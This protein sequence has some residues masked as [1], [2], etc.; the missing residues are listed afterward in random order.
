MT[1]PSEPLFLARQSYRR[2]RLAD[3][4]KVLPVL[5]TILLLMPILWKGGATT[6][7]GLVY[8]FTVWALL[9][10]AVGL[11][12]ARLAREQPGDGGE[13]EGEGGP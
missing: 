2:R 3:A 4:A 7:G 9:I 13:A 10:L 1:R 12:S 8:V 11:V 6:A 5:G